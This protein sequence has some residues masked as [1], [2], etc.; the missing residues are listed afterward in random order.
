MEPTG[1]T[2]LYS[3]GAAAAAEFKC[4]ERRDLCRAAAFLLKTPLRAAQSTSEYKRVSEAWESAFLP[5]SSFSENAFKAVRRL[6]R[7]LR[8]LFFRLML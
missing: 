8:F 1:R 5:A 6:L 7:V 4:L 2:G 3:L